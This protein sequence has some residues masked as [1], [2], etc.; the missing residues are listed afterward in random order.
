[1]YKDRATYLIIAN[2]P[3]LRFHG[4]EVNASGTSRSYV[5]RMCNHPPRKTPETRGKRHLLD[6]D[7]FFA[8]FF[9]VV[10]IEETNLLP[11]SHASEKRGE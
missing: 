3:L 10:T 4:A 1:M 8:H 5:Y 11:F 7:G 6:V 9:P 2:C